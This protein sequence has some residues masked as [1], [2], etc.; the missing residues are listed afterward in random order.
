MA[1]KEMAVLDSEPAPASEQA[2][3][4]VLVVIHPFGDYRRG[5]QIT[6]ADDIAAIESSENAHHCRKAFP[7]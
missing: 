6:N 1:D 7:Q 5:D 2:P 4:P 3:E